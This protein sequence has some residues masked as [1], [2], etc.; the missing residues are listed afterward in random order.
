MSS[1]WKKIQIR[2]Y[3]YFIF[4]KKNVGPVEKKLAFIWRQSWDKITP[5]TEHVEQVEDCQHH[6]QVEGGEEHGQVL[7][8]WVEVPGETVFYQ[9]SCE[10][11]CP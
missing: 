4:I 3:F 2:N 10:V 8:G 1:Y 6:V 9:Q 11:K 7:H 5:F